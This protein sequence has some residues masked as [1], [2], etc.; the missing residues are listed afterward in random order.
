MSTDRQDTS[1]EQQR[2][3]LMTFCA[4]R[5]W[6]I[7]DWYVDAG[8][9]GSTD[10]RPAFQRMMADML[11]PRPPAVAVVVWA[12]SRFSRDLNDSAFYKASLRRR[13]IAVVSMTDSIPEGLYGGLIEYV[14][15]LQSEQFLQ[16]LRV[17]TR[18]GLHYAIRNGRTPGRPPVG[19]RRAWR[20]EGGRMVQYWEIDE[21][22]AQ[23][24]RRAFEMR[25]AGAN[26]TEIHEATHLL[27]A[28]QSYLRMFGNPIYEGVL[29]VG[30]EEYVGHVRE[31]I[32]PEL[33]QTCQHPA[34]RKVREN[35]P[36]LLSGLVWCG[37]CNLQLQ[38]HR[39]SRVIGERRYTYHY[40]ECSLRAFRRHERCP[41]GSAHQEVVEELVLEDL[42][43]RILEPAAAWRLIEAARAELAA[44][45][46]SA[47]VD[48]LAGKI[49]RCNRSL[50]R[51]ARAL[52]DPDLDYDAVSAQMREQRAE[53][54]RLQ[55]ELARQDRQS[56][57][58][59]VSYE[60]VRAY[61]ELL[62]ADLRSG[63]VERARPAL[64]RLV[65]RIDVYEDG[66][67]DVRYAA[68][69]PALLAGG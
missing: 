16:T 42:E 30:S 46:D 51:L 43:R 66:R 20:S 22:A 15:D 57:I 67:I 53:L 40:Y 29:R 32:S 36:Y 6:V 62:R 1:I 10:A 54:G 8:I 61:C 25:A 56:V 17:N 21:E 12:F 14:A 11:G 7:V 50:A 60:Q 49:E 9:S 64:R 45:Q 68:G 69:V 55:A 44:R 19:Y 38:G 26:I 4:T 3:E 27:G 18:R 2:A 5:G 23:L 13:G 35:S 58:A 47:A 28:R 48:E 31:I 34:R 59:D 39:S 37:A 33:W 52:A 65:E 63:Y 41:L 24:V